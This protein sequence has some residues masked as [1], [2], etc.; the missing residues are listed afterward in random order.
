M[1]VAKEKQQ[2]AFLAAGR[3]T[4]LIREPTDEGTGGAGRAAIKQATQPTL[5]GNVPYV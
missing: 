4:G 1:R 2:A 3:E 5:Y